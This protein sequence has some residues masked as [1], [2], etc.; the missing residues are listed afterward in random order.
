MV[1][2]SRCRRRS[3]D[4]KLQATHD[5]LTGLPNRAGLTE[6]IATITSTAALQ[7]AHGAVVFVDLD[8]LKV[9]NDSIGHRA[10]DVM[11]ATIADRLRARTG[12]A[13]TR[14]GGDEFV[15]ALADVSSPGAAET[16]GR[17]IIDDAGQPISVDGHTLRPSVSI[18]IAL[19]ETGADADEMLRRADV[20]L[21]RAKAS[22]RRQVAIY[23]PLDDAGARSRLDLEPELRRAIDRDEFEV[24]YQPIV[25]LASG[26]VVA[27]EALLRWRHPERGVLAPDAFLAEAVANGL[28]GA[29]GAATFQQVC[30]DFSPDSRHPALP[31]AVSVNLSTSELTDR[32]VVSRVADAIARH[33]LDPGCLAIEITEDVI[34]DDSVRRTIDQ[35][36]GLGVRLSIDDFGTGNSSLRQLGTYP[37][38]VLKVDKQFIDRLEHDDEAVLVTRAILGLADR[39]GLRTVA[40]G[41]EHAAQLEILSEM[42]CNQRAGLALRPSDAHRGVGAVVLDPGETADHRHSRQRRHSQRHL[43]RGRRAR[44]LPIR[45]GRGAQTRQGVRGVG[46]DALEH[47]G[48]RRKVRDHAHDLTRRQDPHLCVAVHHR[49]L[50]HHRRVRRKRHL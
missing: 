23:H 30:S 42:G 48:D 49:R 8:H 16:L 33:G 47:L 46:H 18:G 1:W 5:P 12:P 2:R 28:L 3:T 32:R 50:G 31:D 9:V 10:G 41:V 29:I 38:D 35:L 17:L 7:H 26:S 13:V 11:I 6:R 37:A 4:S 19:S 21:Y 15:V 34:V 45:R 27:A 39:L 40:E 14:F 24:H 20:A 25:E 44:E 43:R 22:G 36:R